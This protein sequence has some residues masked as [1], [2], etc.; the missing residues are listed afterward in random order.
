MCRNICAP[1]H[2]NT[3][4]LLCSYACGAV[5]PDLTA[6]SIPSRP[7]LCWA[8]S[9]VASQA[10]QAFA[11]ATQVV[12]PHYLL[13]EMNTETFISNEIIVMFLFLDVSLNSTYRPLI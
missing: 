5:L 10:Q 7:G 8:M 2:I 11:S 6:A 13:S 9:R 3:L 1:S 12:M 4:I